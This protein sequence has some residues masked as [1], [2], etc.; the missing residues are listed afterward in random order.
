MTTIPSQFLDTL[1]VES[2]QENL[3]EFL[4]IR[5]VPWLIRKLI[6][7]KMKNSQFLIKSSSN[8]EY[9][10]TTGNRTKSLQY[11]F[12]LDEP[13]T[14]VGY[15]GKRHKITISVEGDKLKEV[16]LNLERDVGEDIFYFYVQDN[17]LISE[18]EAISGGKRCT[19]KR[20]FLKSTN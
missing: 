3:D 12:K 6:L 7:G 13:F 2:S 16:H 18:C 17:S 1:F 10:Y 20:T 14:D 9:T 11:R 15:D 8:G 19:W 5:D 4:S